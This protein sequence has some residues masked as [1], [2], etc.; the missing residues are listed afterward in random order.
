V[1]EVFSLLGLAVGEHALGHRREAESALQE[2]IAKHADGAAFQIAGACAYLGEVDL[3]FDW[4]ERADAQRDPGVVEIKA[5]ILLR[6]V[7]GDPRWPALLGRM[8]LQ[9]RSPFR[10]MATD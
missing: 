8:G 5:E 10:V 6:N 4:L 3:A 9:D 7:Y 2:L 1:N